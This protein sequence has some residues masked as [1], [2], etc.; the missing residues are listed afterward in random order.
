[1]T[2]FLDSNIWIY[3]LNQSQDIRKHQI[4][5]HLA[6]QT[7]LYLSTQVINEV[8]VNL[9]KKGKFP[10]NQIQNL[11]QGFYQIHHIIELDLNI[12]LKSSTLRTKYLFSFWDSLIIASALS[13]NVNQ[14]YS[15]DMQHGFTVEGLQIINPFL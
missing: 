10:E 9:I 11:I 1:M 4:A 15:E 8:C 7:G 14:L 3:A 5:N 12:L 6:T 13:V 2:T